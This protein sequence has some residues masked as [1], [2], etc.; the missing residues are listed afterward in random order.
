MPEDQLDSIEQE[1]AEMGEEA[2]SGSSGGSSGSKNDLTTKLLKKFL[3]KTGDKD[4]ETY[5]ESSFNPSSDKGNAHMLRAA[6]GWGI[7]HDRALFDFVYGLGIKMKSLIGEINVST[8]GNE[9]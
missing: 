1:L 2:A 4:L 9:G 5:K 3:G 8:G 7:G 6:D